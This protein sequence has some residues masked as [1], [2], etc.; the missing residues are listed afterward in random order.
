[1]TLRYLT[2][3]LAQQIDTELMNPEIGGFAVEQLM[4]LAGL[5]V[6][7]S[8]AKEYATKQYPRVLVCCGPGNNGGDGLVCARHLVHFG[9][10]PV[11][12]YPKPGRHQLFQQLVRQCR[13]LSIPIADD[14]PQRMVNEAD[15]IVDSVFGFSFNGSVREPFTQVINLF[16]TTKL[17]IVSVDIP[18]GWDVEQGCRSLGDQTFQPDMLVSLTAP[19]QGARTF[20]G[21]FHYLGGRFIPPEMAKQ[22]ELNLPDYPGTDQCVRLPTTTQ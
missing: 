8:I 20:Q 21:R 6:A 7:Q 12:Y 1:M 14:A 2:Q 10:Q 5:S 16:R 11:V 22:Y 9:Y 4:E 15:I 13:N 19:K 18:S 17:P 3:Q